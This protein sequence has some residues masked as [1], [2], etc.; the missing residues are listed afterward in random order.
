MFTRWLVFTIL[1]VVIMLPLLG[2]KWWR[3]LLAGKSKR[4]FGTFYAAVHF[5]I[6][7]VVASVA[8]FAL[9]WF[10]PVKSS[11]K[12]TVTVTSKRID[13]T[14][15]TGRKAYQRHTYNHYRVW[16]CRP[17]GAHGMV[18][19]PTLDYYNRCR[20]GKRLEVT[21]EVKFWGDTVYKLD[22]NPNIKP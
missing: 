9:E 22:Y 18:E 8:F 3:R 2:M 20:R 13:Q 6:A 12:M 17:D 16:F 4:G 7:V 11:E 19:V 1:V 5:A 10:G 21:E 15:T 14:K